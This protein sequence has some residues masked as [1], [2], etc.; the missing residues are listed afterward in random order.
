MTVW[1]LEARRDRQYFKTLLETAGKEGLRKEVLT[2]MA[3]QQDRPQLGVQMVR[4][5]AT[6]ADPDHEIQFA[7]LQIPGSPVEPVDGMARIGTNEARAPRFSKWV[8]SSRTSRAASSW[9]L[10]CPPT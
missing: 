9:P 4:G 5:R 7:F 1:E 6:N 8:G 10:P 2:S 3:R